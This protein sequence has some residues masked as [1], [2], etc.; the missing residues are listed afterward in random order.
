MKYGFCGRRFSLLLVPFCALCLVHCG[1][2]DT[3]TQCVPSFLKGGSYSFLTR[4]VNDGCAG[5][6]LAGLVP[7][8][9]Y[10]M[11]LPPVS[12]LPATIT[13]DLPFVGEVDA[14]LS[15]SGNTVQIIT[16]EISGTVDYLGM[17]W[18]YV[19]AVSGILC[20]TS[21]AL[22]DV[23]LAVNLISLDPADF[24]VPCKVVI[25]LSGGR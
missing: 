4:T 23:S 12:E 18:A 9:P 5:G 16:D 25:T 15:L 11:D 6:V 3:T 17:T 22:A 19:A 2:S 20:P 13:L 8:G 14:D 7:A 24:P 10:V 1:G 21:P